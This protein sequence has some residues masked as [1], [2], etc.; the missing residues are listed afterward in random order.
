VEDMERYRRRVLGLANGDAPGTPFEF[1]RR[2]TFK[3]I[4]DMIEGG[5]FYLDKDYS[6]CDS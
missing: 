2:A 6:L 1:K 3:P 4:E 5:P